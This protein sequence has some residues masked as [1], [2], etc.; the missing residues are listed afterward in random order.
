MKRDKVLDELV[1][2]EATLLKKHATRQEL[3]NLDYDNLDGSYKYSCI[4]GQITGNCTNKRANQLIYKCAKRIY[5]S[6]EE[7]TFGG[8]LNGAPEK[9]TN[10]SNRLFYYVSP[11]EK[12]LYMYKKHTDLQSTKVRKLVKF[13]KGEIDQLTF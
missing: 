6:D 11:I 13:L 7:D 10:D 12:F 2:E 1:I 9:I 8:K 3:N 5:L 4:Y